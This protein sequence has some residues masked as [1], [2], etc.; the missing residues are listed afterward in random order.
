MATTKLEQ[1]APGLVS[2]DAAAAVTII[3]PCRQAKGLMLQ[4]ECGDI[5]GAFTFKERA[6]PDQTF[7]ASGRTGTTITNPSGSARN[8]IYLVDFGNA[9]PYDMELD[10]SHTSGGEFLKIGVQVL[11]Q[12]GE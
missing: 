11:K 9:P 7:K 3:I 4:I 2:Q 8:D 6:H 12:I 10:Y 1:N 5:T